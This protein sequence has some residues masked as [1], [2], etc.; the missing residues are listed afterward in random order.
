MDKMVKQMKVIDVN[1]ENRDRVRN[2][3]LSLCDQGRA[4]FLY[5]NMIGGASLMLSPN[6]YPKVAP[7]HR[8]CKCGGKP[9]TTMHDN[10]DW[11][12]VCPNCGCRST[13][14]RTPFRALHAWDAG[15]LE[16]DKENLTIWE[17]M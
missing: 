9:E 3:Y 8:T 14:A 4:N 11:S 10:G 1:A 7:M 16:T 17:V 6:Q 5:D 13:K 15:L 2:Y 12:A